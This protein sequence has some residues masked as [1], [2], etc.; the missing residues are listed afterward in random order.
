MSCEYFINDDTPGIYLCLI[1]G[2]IQRPQ[3]MPVMGNP[4]VIR[5]CAEC[6]HEIGNHE[7]TRWTSWMNQLRKNY[8]KES[9]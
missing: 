3:W 8:L 2:D 5:V 1:C 7:R 9:F 4:Q 6:G